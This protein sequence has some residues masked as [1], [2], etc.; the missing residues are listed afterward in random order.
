MS[1]LGL[2]DQLGAQMGQ[3]AIM[4]FLSKE[5]KTEFVFFKEFLNQGRGVK[6][7]EPFDLP[8]RILEEKIRY[9]RIYKYLA[10]A[11]FFTRIPPPVG[12][13]FNN[14][15][16]QLNLRYNYDIRG[17]FGSVKYWGKYNDEIL[18]IFTFRKS[19]QTFAQ[20][21]IRRIGQGY[22]EGRETVS[23]HFRRKDYLSLA[24]L[25][26]SME[27]YKRALSIF[28]DIKSY[29]ILVFSDDIEYCKTL[30]IFNSMNVCF[31]EQNKSYVDMCIMSLCNHNIIA[32]S[33]F[34]LWGALLNRSNHKTVICPKMYVGPNDV[35]N[36]W[37]NGHYFPSDWIA[38]NEV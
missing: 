20:S 23:I 32:N 9:G 29:T 35:A 11:S 8:N 13:P 4:H 12:R 5:L 21:F 18:D 26:L 7:F 22:G 33:S 38:L 6:L 3:Y 31:V 36:Q 30:D 28:S 37:I 16:L 2:G 34:S 24:S 19:I 14:G 1:N 15:L 27:Y 25:N 17:S 10:P